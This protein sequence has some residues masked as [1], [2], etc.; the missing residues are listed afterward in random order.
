MKSPEFQAGRAASLDEAALSK[1]R[2]EIEELLGPTPVAV[3][4]LLRQCQ[5]SPALVHMVLLELELAGRIDRHAGNRV[6]MIAG[7]PDAA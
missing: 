3:D 7:D 4:E 2:G 5:V 1:A 6:A